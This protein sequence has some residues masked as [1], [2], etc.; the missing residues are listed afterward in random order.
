[1]SFSKFGYIISY[2][3]FL[4]LPLLFVSCSDGGNEEDSYMITVEKVYGD[5]TKYCAFTSLI[6]R[7]GFYYLAFREADSHVGEGDYGQIK[8]L[9]SR[10][11]KKWNHYQTIKA[12]NID[13]R[14]PNL[15][16]TPEGHLLLL[17]G[18]RMKKQ[19]EGYFYTKSYYAIENGGV[20]SEVQPCNIPPEID[21]PY[22]CWLWKLT[23][24]RG[25]GYG[26]AYRNDGITNKLTLLSTVDGINYTVVTDINANQI[27]NETR[28]QFLQNNE[29]V[30]LI[31]SENEGYI[32]ISFPPYTEWNLKKTN[33]YLAGQDFIISD[34]HLICATRL[35]TNNGERTVLWFGDLEGNFQWSYV[36][37][38]SGVRGD[39]AYT[40]IIDEKY[41]LLLSYYSMHQTNKPAIYL[42]IIPKAT[43][44]YK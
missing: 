14:D 8:T 36:L 29:M 41:R 1:M 22:C 33:I 16:V 17:C 23:W 32:G 11:A 34:N 12:Y 24:N 44:P 25:I 31:R 37:P 30:A 10:D 40:G 9:Y 27:V 43:L 38:S 39:T 26:A 7:G 19:P 2:I 13:L 18:A 35:A 3:F 42:A 5:G 15:S 28:I 4:I 6:K 20:F 21:D